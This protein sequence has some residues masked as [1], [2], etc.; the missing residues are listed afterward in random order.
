MLAFP[1]PGTWSIQQIIMHLMDSDLI[2][3][4]RMNF[5]KVIAELCGRVTVLQS[6]EILAEGSY[7]EVS[8]DP[9]VIEAYVGGAND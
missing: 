4:D 3:S 9:A 2:A 5:A 7:E 1:I 8:R 6:G